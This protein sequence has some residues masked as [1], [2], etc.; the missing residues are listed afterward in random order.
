MPAFQDLLTLQL[1]GYSPVSL[2]GNWDMAES[3]TI[4]PRPI[5]TDVLAAMGATG[6]VPQAQW[7]TPMQRV[8]WG[9]KEAGAGCGE[10]KRWLEGT[11]SVRCGW[12]QC[13]QRDI[14]DHL[15]SV[16]RLGVFRPCL[17][18]W[19]ERKFIWVYAMSAQHARHDHQHFLHQKS[20]PRST[21]P[22]IQYHVIG[23]RVGEIVSTNQLRMTLTRKSSSSYLRCHETG[24]LTSTYTGAYQEPRS[25]RS[26][27]LSPTLTVI[28]RLMTW[29]L[30]VDQN[31]A[32]CAEWPQAVT[33]TSER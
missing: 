15:E 19:E 1:S 5:G 21:S 24:N 11:D 33:S 17:W 27:I 23:V 26:E 3:H 25:S 14:T 29:L 2:L 28:D 9:P 18:R 12:E 31:T 7:C 8:S 6:V 30:L 10:M 13:S 20:N 4:C 22:R 32:T 16:A